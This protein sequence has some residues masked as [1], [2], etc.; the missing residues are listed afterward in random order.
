MLKK[1]LSRLSELSDLRL[2]LARYLVNFIGFVEIVCLPL[3][4]DPGFYTEVELMRQ[5]FLMAPLLIL[6]T[7]SGYLICLYKERRDLQLSLVTMTVLIGVGISAVV[8]VTVGSLLPALAVFLMIL[9][10]GLEKVLVAQGALIVASIYKAM[11][12]AALLG[13]GLYAYMVKLE[14]SALTLYSGCVVVGVLLWGGVIWFSADLAGLRAQINLRRSVREFV[15]LAQHGFLISVQS[16]ILV[17]YFL[18]DRFVVN[19]YYHGHASEYALGFS[20]SQIIFIAVNTVAFA[21]QHK[22]GVRLDE[23]SLKNYNQMLTT[24]FILF[25][26]L[27]GVAVPMV[28]LFSQVIDGYGS[29]INSFFLIAIFFGGYYAISAIAVIG[30]YQGMARKAL[31][32]VVFFFLL[33]AVITWGLIADGYGY[34]GNLVK[35]GLLLLLSAAVFDQMIRRE[36]KRR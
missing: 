5:L 2:F 31:V 19:S 22:V 14:V 3:L 6:G 17:G 34:Y 25:V 15:D 32:V 27:L 26:V 30:F 21:A 18:F 36:F 12:S 13:V 1:Y 20:L 33:N 29:F 8:S 4:F 35:S 24:T 11:I 7:H 9:V 10:A 28:Y 16:Y 23:F